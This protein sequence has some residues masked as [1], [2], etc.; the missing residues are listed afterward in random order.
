MDEVSLFEF[1]FFLCAVGVRLRDEA[2]RPVTMRNAGRYGRLFGTASSI[3][4][5]GT[6]LQCRG[7]K[8]TT[9]FTYQILTEG[10]ATWLRV[11]VDTQPRMPHGKKDGI[12]GG[13]ETRE[14]TFCYGRWQKRVCVHTSGTQDV[15]HTLFTGHRW[16][17]SGYEHYQMYLCAFAPQMYTPSG[18][19]HDSHIERPIKTHQCH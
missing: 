14:A 1:T 19:A 7:F 6:D 12:V 11:A 15:F 17:G 10:C 4:S 5:S 13:K 8:R 3:L 16:A 2:T 9:G 18:L